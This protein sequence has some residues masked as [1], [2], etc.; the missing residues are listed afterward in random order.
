MKYPHQWIVGEMSQSMNSHPY[1][2]RYIKASGRI[3]L[4]AHIVQE[5]HNDPA[6]QHVALWPEGCQWHGRKHQGGGDTLTTLHEL[7]PQN[8]LP[9]TTASDPQDFQVIRQAKMLALAQALKAC[10]E[11]SGV[12]TG[13]LCEAV[14]ELQQCMAPLVTFSGGDVVEASLLRPTR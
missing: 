12:K 1:W 8:I 2:G 3:S 11:A 6:P 10:A 7:C 9:L 14:R 4:G 13:I 5:G